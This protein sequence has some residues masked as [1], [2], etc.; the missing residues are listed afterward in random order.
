MVSVRYLLVHVP[1]GKISTCC[2]PF[3]STL[4]SFI[5]SNVFF[6]ESGSVR[7]T[8]KGCVYLAYY[9]YSAGS[10]VASVR[11]IPDEA[12]EERDIFCL[13]FG[14]N[15]GGTHDSNRKGIKKCGVW[16]HTK[17]WGSLRRCLLKGGEG[18]II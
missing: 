14:N 7:C 15:T 8:N 9:V 4:L 13:G 16:R 1:S 17:D 18:E 12:A 11:T 5:V 10:W 6:R 2:H 3:P